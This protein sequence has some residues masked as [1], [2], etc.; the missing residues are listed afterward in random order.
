M[1]ALAQGPYLWGEGTNHKLGEKPERKKKEFLLR[2]KFKERDK[3]IWVF[4]TKV[5]VERLNQ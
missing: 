5:F 3:K 4:S 1:K 2:R